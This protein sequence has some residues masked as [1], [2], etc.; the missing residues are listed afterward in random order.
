[1]DNNIKRIVVEIGIAYDAYS[2][3]IIGLD[4]FEK[5]VLEYFNDIKEWFNEAHNKRGKSFPFS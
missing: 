1:M 5:V 3:G 4:T 2:F